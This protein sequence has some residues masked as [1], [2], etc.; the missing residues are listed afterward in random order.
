MGP[1]Q[2]SL[3]GAPPKPT[4]LRFYQ[5][6]AVPLAE[7]ALAEHGS[8]ILVMATGLGKTE[9][10]CEVIRRWTGGDILCLAHSD[11]L[12]EQLRER[13]ERRTHVRP[14]VDKA[15]E[16]APP[17]A[18]CVVAS[19]AT[20]R[21]KR[22]LERY[23]KDKFALI[24][25][26]EVH[27]YTGNTF[28]RPFEYFGEAHRFGVT[29]TPK[30]HDMKALGRWFKS[31]CMIYD[32]V[33]G[34]RDGFIV[35]FK[36]YGVL[37]EQIDLRHVKVTNGDYDKGALDDEMLKGIAPIVDEI[38]EKHPREQCILF[39]PGV[40]SA[41]AAALRFNAKEEGS[42][43]FV[44]GETPKLERR[45]LVAAFKSGAILRFCNCAVA[46]EGFDAPPCSVIG[47]ARPTRSL[48]L[49]TQMVGRGTRVLPGLI[50]HLPL[51]HQAEER[52]A[53]IAQSPKPHVTILDF[54]GVCP[55]GLLKTPTDVLGG[56][57][58]EEERKLAKKRLKTRPGTDVLEALEAARKTLMDRLRNT[59]SSTRTRRVEL[60]LFKLCKTS[61]RSL[62]F[63]DSKYGFEPATGPQL[64]ALR[65]FGFPDDQAQGLSKRGARKLLNE[66]CARARG[67][68]ASVKQLRVLARS[69]LCETSLTREQA[70]RAIDWARHRW[71]RGI[72]P[73][74]G[75]LLAVAVGMQ[76][77]GDLAPISRTSTRSASGPV[78]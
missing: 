20:I 70:S 49:V 69:G 12:V 23:P 2:L 4:A 54:R 10:I 18:Q 28:V 22:R 55:D 44:S 24:V 11:E 66:L 6:R 68:L 76:P 17:W 1:D 33:S 43:C 37:V 47:L 34:I 63:L 5:E 36:S 53:L 15:E 40:K 41:E 19:I 42:A 73:D 30:R 77:P 61:E 31:C 8:T 51:E 59:V 57:Y 64:E 71:N 56:T 72:Q 16:K 48:S 46:T 7:S 39:L 32:I 27:H 60:D 74:A 45:R 65:K 3:F 50:D 75:Q 14:Y 29:A 62:E 38:L 58:S 52:R 21:Q 35:P 67:G 78:R 9:I 26:D 13:I 25:I